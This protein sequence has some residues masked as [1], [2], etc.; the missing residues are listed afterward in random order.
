MGGE[1]GSVLQHLETSIRENLGRDDAADGQVPWGMLQQRV[2]PRVDA[3][4]APE[5]VENTHV[6]DEGGEGA[7]GGRQWRR[8]GQLRCQQ[9]Q[10]I[11]ERHEHLVD[12]RRR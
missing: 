4:Q 7:T 1:V 9:L 5:A 3:K 11:R 12:A 2:A 8:R 6:G 10:R